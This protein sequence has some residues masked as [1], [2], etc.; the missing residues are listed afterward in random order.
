[1]KRAV[2]ALLIDVLYSVK[3]SVFLFTELRR[4]QVLWCI[5]HSGFVTEYTSIDCNLFYAAY[6]PS[7][8]FIEAL[9]TDRTI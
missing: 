8:Y 4:V 7:V 3:A 6:V 1:M 2:V 9:N 5:A